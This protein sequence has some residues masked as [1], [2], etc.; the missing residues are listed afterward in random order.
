MFKLTIIDFFRFGNCSKCVERCYAKTKDFYYIEIECATEDD[1]TAEILKALMVRNV[2]RAKLNRTEVL[3][4]G[5][6]LLNINWHNVRM[7]SGEL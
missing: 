7:I 5:A 1:I 2:K 4:D 6:E 3:I